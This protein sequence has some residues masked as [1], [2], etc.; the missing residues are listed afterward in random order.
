MSV[1]KWF[2]TFFTAVA[3]VALSGWSCERSISFKMSIED[4]LKLAG[5]APTV[6]RAEGFLAKAVAGIEAR[7]LTQGNSALVFHTPT[8]DLGIWYQQ[9]K[10]AH[11]TTQS[12]IN[13]ERS[14]QPVPQL[15]R[16][17]AL[18]KIRETVLDQGE[19]MSVTA[20]QNAWIYPFQWLRIILLIGAVM[21][22]G[23]TVVLFMADD[24]H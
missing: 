4:N 7:G 17:N 5:D 8:Q 16:D 2:S 18:M 11:Q 9:V 20:P 12:I 22:V 6:E 15:E 23:I 3:I 13:R 21:L 24:G 10:G 14:G 1:A 19:S